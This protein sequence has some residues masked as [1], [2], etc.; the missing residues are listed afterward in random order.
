MDSPTPTSPQPAATTRTANLRIGDVAR[1]V[2]TTP[3]TIRYYEEIGLLS[4]ASTRPSGRHRLY[5]QAEAEP[6]GRSRR[7]ARSTE[8][9]R[10]G[11]HLR[12]GRGHERERLP[13]A[14]GRRRTPSGHDRD[15]RGWRAGRAHPRRLQP[16]RG[17]RLRDAGGRP[18]HP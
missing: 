18:L 11:A 15:P 2:G 16:L 4:E 13:V 5:T 14:W 10:R 12:G 1:L 7:G 6:R 8:P 3:R 9:A 17:P